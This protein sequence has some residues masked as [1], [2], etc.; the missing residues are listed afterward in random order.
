M[1]LGLLD[2][3]PS[4]IAEGVDLNDYFSFPARGNLSVKVDSSTTSAG[5][6]PKNSKFGIPSVF[7][8]KRM[9]CFFSL[10][11]GTKAEIRFKDNGIRGRRG[12]TNPLGQ[13]HGS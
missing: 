8:L 3:N 6:D 5:L 7:N 2:Q 12:S 1:H 13:P 9:D 4:A 10:G 11:N